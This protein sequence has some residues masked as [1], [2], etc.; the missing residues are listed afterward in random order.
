MHKEEKKMRMKL[1]PAT[2]GHENPQHL[3][4]PCFFQTFL[5]A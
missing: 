3:D 5:Q 2:V 4:K 1:L